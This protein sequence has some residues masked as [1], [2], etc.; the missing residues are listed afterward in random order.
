MSQVLERWTV[1]QTALAASGIRK[2]DHIVDPRSGDPVRRRRGAWV[3]IGRTEGSAA[4]AVADALTTACMLLG[5]DEIEQLCRH[6]PGVE[7][8]ILSETELRHFGA[9][10]GTERGTKPL[11]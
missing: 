6:S 7:A 3:T 2:R 1:R 10:S 11:G 8:W 4:A 9:A 5:G